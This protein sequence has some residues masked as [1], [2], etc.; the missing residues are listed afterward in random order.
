LTRDA[1]DCSQ[2]LASGQG[3]SAFPLQEP[4]WQVDSAYFGLMFNVVRI[5]KKRYKTMK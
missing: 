4:A 3:K 1:R 2:N 5:D